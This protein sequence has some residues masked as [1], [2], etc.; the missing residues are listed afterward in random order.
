MGMLNGANAVFHSAI[1]CLSK[2]NQN[3]M[4]VVAQFVVRVVYLNVKRW[5]CQD[6]IAIS[7]L[8]KS[9][10]KFLFD[11][12]DKK[13]WGA[14]ILQSIRACSVSSNGELMSESLSESFF[15]LVQ[16]RS[17]EI[18]HLLSYWIKVFLS[19]SNGNIGVWVDI[20]FRQL[21]LTCLL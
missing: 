4:F 16:C 1:S 2:A 10:P 15:T 11:G 18:I 6:C 3:L 20:S 9:N 13:G 19:K 21:T 5:S 8:S 7:C 17:H 12:E 14:W